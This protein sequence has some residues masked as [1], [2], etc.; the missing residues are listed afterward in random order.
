ML[1]LSNFCEKHQIWIPETILG[2]VKGDARPPLM[3]RWKA[4]GQLFVRLN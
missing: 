1:L 2:E 4:H 3:A